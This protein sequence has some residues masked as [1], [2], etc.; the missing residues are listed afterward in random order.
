MIVSS[1]SV[2]P[3]FV[4][5]VSIEICSGRIGAGK[6]AENLVVPYTK[7]VYNASHSFKC[8]TVTT[9]ILIVE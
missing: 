3:T 9:V 1:A 4:D 5:E 8:V 6:K 2:T 7:G